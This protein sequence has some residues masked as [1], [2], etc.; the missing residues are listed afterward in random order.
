MSEREI[1]EAVAENYRIAF[2]AAV[3]QRDEL[4]EVVDELLEMQHEYPTELS[5]RAPEWRA[6]FDRA[7]AVR[8]RA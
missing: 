4:R 5:R 6:A 7:R 3:A 1:L 8:S 2:E